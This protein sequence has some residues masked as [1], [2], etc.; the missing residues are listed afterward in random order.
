MIVVRVVYVAAV[1]V[2]VI[3][4]LQAG[5]PLGGLLLVPAAAIW[6]RH[7]AESGRLAARARRAL[8]YEP[9]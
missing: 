4:L 6:L 3:R 2:L 8:R 1:M 9:N 7:E 5:N